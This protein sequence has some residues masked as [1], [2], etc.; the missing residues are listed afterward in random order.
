MNGIKDL[1]RALKGE[2]VVIII[3]IVTEAPG[4]PLSGRRPRTNTMNTRAGPGGPPTSPGPPR[5][6]GGGP[7]VTHR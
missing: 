3:I 6:E 7:E 2:G 1:N 4:R 5:Q